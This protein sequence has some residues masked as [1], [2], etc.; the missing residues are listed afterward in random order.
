MISLLV[1]TRG[2]PSGL[3]RMVDSAFEHA[4]APGTFEV[5]AVVDDDDFSYEG[6]WELYNT[7]TIIKTKRTLLSLYWNLAY[8]EAKGPIYMHASDDIVFQ[9][10]DWD[11]K[12]E[13]AFDKYPD[14]I[15]FVYGDDGDPTHKNFGTHG[16]L[17]KQ[18][19]DA[20]GYFV[21]PYFSSDWNDTWLNEVA[22]KIGRKEK[23]DI[24]TEHMHY[25]LRKGELDLTHAERLVRHFKDNTPR[26]YED[27]VAE[28]NTDAAKLREA[29]V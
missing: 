12:V 17:H 11:L 22:D 3:R 19:V 14:K 13:E 21:P 15:V 7:T 28:R 2:R 6:M 23:I 5:V 27:K 25:G 4:S 26:I 24:L 29:M 16:F 9:T 10:P 18:W 20:V 1:P 8:E